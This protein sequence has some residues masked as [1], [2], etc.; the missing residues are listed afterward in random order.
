MA[1][2]PLVTAPDPRLKL[3]SQRIERVD[4]ELRRFMKDMLETMYE[5]NGV[6]LAAIQVG[7]PKRVAVIDVDSKGKNSKPLCFVNPSIVWRSNEMVDHHEGCL[8]VPEIWDDVGRHER[9]KV[10]YMDE[11]GKKQ[12]L[13]ADGLL[14]IAL[15][16]E[17]D[18]L[19]GKLFV[20]HLSKLKRNIALR[21][22]AKMKR[23]QQTG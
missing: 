22:A 2:L 15:Q 4:D 11:H 12:T 18:H 23:G 17:V 9:V 10:E 5:A 8:S 19:N 3:V 16:H 6:G 14:A 20:D 1:I 21:K 13:E 7:V